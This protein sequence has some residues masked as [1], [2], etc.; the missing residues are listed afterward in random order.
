MINHY[1]LYHI[2]K[3]GVDVY[4]ITSYIHTGVFNYYKLVSPRNWRSFLPRE[5]NLNK[6]AIFQ[7]DYKTNI[8]EEF[9]KKKMYCPIRKPKKGDKIYIING[10]MAFDNIEEKNYFKNITFTV[11]EIVEI[12]DNYYILFVEENHKITV[13]SYIFANDDDLFIM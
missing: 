2:Y 10:T 3:K 4:K 9:F 5:I 6:A 11:K 13:Y 7:K 12:H 1:V 8:A